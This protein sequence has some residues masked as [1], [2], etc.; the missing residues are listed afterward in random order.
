MVNQILDMFSVST[1]WPHPHEQG[2]ALAAAQIVATKMCTPPHGVFQRDILSCWLGCSCAL[3]WGSKQPWAGCSPVCAPQHEGFAVEPSCWLTPYPSQP[4]RSKDICC[5]T[6]HTFLHIWIQPMS[7][8]NP[9]CMSH[10]RCH[11]NT[12]ELHLKTDWPTSCQA[13]KA[14]L[15]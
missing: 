9:D 12:V 15:I 2:C 13:S 8:K 4:L 3:R 5:A 11:K 14:L 10:R 1:V 7:P 6:K